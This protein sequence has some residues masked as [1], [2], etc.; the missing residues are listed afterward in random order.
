MEKKIITNPNID[1]LAD[2][3][4]KRLSN[5]LDVDCPPKQAK[6]IILSIFVRGI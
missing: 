1:L 5:L 2:Y 3:P 6:K 4:F